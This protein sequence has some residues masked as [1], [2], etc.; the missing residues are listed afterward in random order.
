MAH[1]VIFVPGMMG[2]I[3]KLNGQE[4]WPGSVNVASLILPFPRM[5]E[6]LSEDLVATDCIRKVVIVDQYQ[7]LID[8]L[9][10]CGFTEGDTMFVAAYD[11]RKDIARCAEELAQHIDK[12]THTGSSKNEI[13]LLAHSLGG[14]VSRHYLESQRFENRP[15]FSCVRQLITL[16]TPHHGAPKALPA[17]LGQ[18]KNVFLSKDQ[19]REFVNDARYPSLYQVLPSQTE[20]FAWDRSDQKQLDQVDIYDPSVI[21]KLGLSKQ[22]LEAAKEFRK[23]IDTSRRPSNVRYFCFSG[24]RHSTITH[25]MVRLLNTGGS[26]ADKIEIEDG[27]DGT[28][29]TWSSFIIGFQRLFVGAE[30][31]TIFRDLNLRRALATLL[32]KEGLLAG[33]PAKTQVSVRDRVVEPEDIVHVTISFPD[34]IQDFSG[35]LTIELA[36]VNEATGDVSYAQPSVQAPVEYKGLSLET[37]SLVF[38][39]PKFPGIYRVAFRDNINATPSGSDEL[40]VQQP[41]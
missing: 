35:V 2:S 3:L 24:T 39:A 17:A 36:K 32:G 5:N 34:E 41:P 28:V 25:V 14:L 19:V 1:I 15:G 31:G 13:T 8:D 11:W 12:H 18:E 6:L 33:V 26:Q 10:K 29:P 9:E 27:G 4:I 20:P 22:N 38:E 21:K 23:S 37:V 16:G 30:H 7:Q 40:I